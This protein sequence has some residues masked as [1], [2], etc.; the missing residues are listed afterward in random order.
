MLTDRTFGRSAADPK[1]GELRP[2][3]RTQAAS[4]KRRVRLATARSSAR[5]KSSSLWCHGASFGAPLVPWHEML[6][7]MRHA[8]AEDERENEFGADR[9][10]QCPRQGSPQAPELCRLVFVE[11]GQVGH[12]AVALDEQPTQG[13]PPVVARG[14]VVD[15]ELP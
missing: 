9:F 5:G 2:V 14:R 8:E 11:V 4:D 15:P 10:A 12:V 7:E 1:L 6:V 13:G 3:A